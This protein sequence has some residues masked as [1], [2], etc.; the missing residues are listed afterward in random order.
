MSRITWQDFEKVEMRAGKVV[1]VEDF[2]QARNP[3]YL[4]ELDFG[5]P[6]GCLRSVAAIAEYYE[7]EGLVGRTLIA[8]TNFPPKQIGNRM[9]H[10]LVLAVVNYDGSLRL[11]EPDGE[12]ALGARVK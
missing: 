5:S 2:P 4:L 6:I 8:V 10:V 12:V 9:S 3:S 7:K 1:R 11:I